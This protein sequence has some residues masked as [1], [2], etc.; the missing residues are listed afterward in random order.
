MRILEFFAWV[1]SSFHLGF[2][3]NVQIKP[4]VMDPKK[5]SKLQKFNQLVE[6][7]GPIICSISHIAWKGNQSQ[8]KISL[9]VDL[10]EKSI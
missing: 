6:E 5:L 2:F 9:R 3:Q 8:F 10:G 7:N 4:L 1:L